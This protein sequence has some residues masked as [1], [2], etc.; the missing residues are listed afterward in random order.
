M[1]LFAAQ[2][3]LRHVGDDVV[4]FLKETQGS[5]APRFVIGRPQ[6]VQHNR[7]AF[8]ALD[9]TLGEVLGA[10]DP[11]RADACLGA[12]FDPKRGSWDFVLLGGEGAVRRLLV[13]VPPRHARAFGKTRLHAL[14]LRAPGSGAQRGTQSESVAPRREWHYRRRARRP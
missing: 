13:N 5:N 12:R 10:L 3:R 8:A 1:G 4:G 11:K 6:W 14:G 9:P 7:K 2:S